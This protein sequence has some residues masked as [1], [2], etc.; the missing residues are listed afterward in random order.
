M[1]KRNN[2]RRHKGRNGGPR[3]PPRG[4][5]D[6][7]VH[8]TRPPPIKPQMTHRQRMRF[9]CTTSG[10]QVVNFADIM[11]MLLV[12]T[13]ATAVYDVYD[14]CRVNLV[15]VWCASASGGVPV[16]V[17]V[18]FN[19]ANSVGQAGDGRI[20]ADTVMGNEPAHV[21]ARPDRRSIAGQWGGSASGVA[22]FTVVT[23]TGSIIDVDVSYRNTVA[24]PALAQ[25]VAVGATVG[26]FYYRG[27][28]GVA[29]ATT[30]Y[31][32]L[33]GAQGGDVI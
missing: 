22:A 9:Q 14:V 30:K 18:Q 25:V 2:G 12:A 23:P 7:L 32:P 8:T 21:R 27:L 10:T 31:P 3:G 33:T 13:S 26:Q 24:A 6:V 4:A 11:D 5:M 20:I 16:T 29:T 1:M 15:E 17:S 28:D 19:G